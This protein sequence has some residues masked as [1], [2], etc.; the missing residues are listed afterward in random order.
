VASNLPAIIARANNQHPY[1]VPC[2]VALPIIDANPEYLNWIR[3][4]T[5]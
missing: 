3:M 1:E 4:E 2:V 5:P